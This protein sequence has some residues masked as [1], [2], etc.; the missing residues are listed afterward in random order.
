[1][2]PTDTDY[3]WSFKDGVR[4]AQGDLR[5]DMKAAAAAEGEVPKLKCGP[6]EIIQTIYE[7]QQLQKK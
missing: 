2:Q 5:R 4:K 1:M 6:K 7:A 3:S